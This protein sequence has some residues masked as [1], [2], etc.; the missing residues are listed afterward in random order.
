MR[1]PPLLTNWTDLNEPENQGNTDYETMIHS[2]DEYLCLSSM[3]SCDL[4][5]QIDGEVFYDL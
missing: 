5:C 3:D 4:D 2:D 1:S